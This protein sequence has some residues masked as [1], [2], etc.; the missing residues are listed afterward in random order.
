MQWAGNQY[1][2][3]NQLVMI[4]CTAL[5]VIDPNSLA[6]KYVLPGN[7]NFSLYVKFHS[8]GA[9]A[10]WLTTLAGVQYTVEFFADQRGGP[11]DASIAVVGPKP[12]IAGQTA[13]SQAETEAIIPANTLPQG[14]YE[15][16]AVVSFGGNPDITGFNEAPL[17]QLPN[18]LIVI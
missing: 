3:S 16:T 1:P 12:L 14:V 4:D 17:V 8:S 6:S 5:E 11:F 15:L 9:W 7:Q 2:T 18:P 13:Y 10:Q